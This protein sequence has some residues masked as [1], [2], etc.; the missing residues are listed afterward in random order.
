MRKKKISKKAFFRLVSYG[1]ISVFLIGYF[2]F[3]VITGTYRF[4][5]LKNETSQ[6]E[7]ELDNLKGEEKKLRS[8]ILKLND[9]EYIA[10]YARKHYQY[11]KEGELIIRINEIEEEKEIESE[12]APLAFLLASGLLLIGVVYHLFRKKKPE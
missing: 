3:V 11:S 9:P 10:S 12:P 7:S 4:L 6:L 1:L 2:L 8:E 5:S